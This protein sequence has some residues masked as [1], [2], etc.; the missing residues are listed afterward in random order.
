[1]S[2]PFFRLL[3]GSRVVAGAV[4]LAFALVA[5]GWL[6]QRGTRGEHPSPYQSARLFEEVRQH[7]SRDFVDSIS[8]DQLYRKAVD[9]I[10][11]ELNDPYTKF[12]PQARLDQLAETTSGNYAGVGLQVDIRDGWVIVMASLPGSPAERAGF[13]SGDRILEIN[14]RS[15][16]NWTLEEAGNALR[17]AA[18]SRLTMTVDRVGAATP[19]R[20]TLRRARIHVSAVRRATMLTPDV[21]YIELRAFS[22]STAPELERAIES[23][24]ARGM[25]SLTLDL[26]TNPG[27][28]L[29]QGVR[30]ADMF[31]ER[32]ATLVRT[33][34]RTEDDSHDY[35]DPTPQR[36][37]NLPLTVLVDGRSASAAEIVAGALQDHDRAA[38]VGTPTYGKGS[39]Q[40]VFRL[41]DGGL[42]LTT[43]RWYT[44]A[45]R[46]ITR[47]ER[48]ETEFGLLL[49][50][51]PRDRPRVR[52]LGGRIVRGGGGIV[53]D[54]IAGDTVPNP[55]EA[56][57]NATLGGKATVFRDAL[58]EVALSVK[59][60][61]SVRDP[62]FTVTSGLLDSV[63]QRLQRRGVDMPRMVF[64]DATLV[65]S[66]LLS[67]EIARFVFG[68]EVEFR[69]R[70]ND[71]RALLEAVR[72]AGGARSPRDPLRR[73]AAILEREAPVEPP[74]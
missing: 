72:I 34:G 64:D 7:V 15:T 71:D 66:R 48:R 49:E 54:V 6:V 13:E 50:Q 25:L 3:G 46:S 30:V 18:G 52:T 74:G 59:R 60:A 40:T 42:K 37:P 21:G 26:R 22:D 38:I 41:N 36:W 45:G 8:E 67:Y 9:G 12:L 2:A 35:V 19:F 58:A 1:M 51:G 10:L 29:E 31:L 62:E 17:G 69:R 32:G 5:G 44:P 55:Q 57:L 28:L 4:V 73:V 43:A 70:A 63:Y 14:S 65:V 27:G 20:I 61:G 33:R 39:A 47:R 11:Y 68:P 16:E 56:A 23:L 24:R 53:P